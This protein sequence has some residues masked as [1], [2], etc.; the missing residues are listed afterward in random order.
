MR[1]YQIAAVEKILNKI[2]IANNYKYFG[3]TKAGGYI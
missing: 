1:P 3:S 2:E